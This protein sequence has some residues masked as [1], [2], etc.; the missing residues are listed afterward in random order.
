MD[1]IQK[2]QAAA[3]AALGTVLLTTACGAPRSPELPITDYDQVAALPNGDI[4]SGSIYVLYGAGTVTIP[5]STALLRNGTDPTQRVG[6]PGTTYE[7]GVLMLNPLIAEGANADGTRDGTK[8][9]A[10]AYTQNPVAL[11]ANTVARVINLSISI[12]DKSLRCAYTGETA[13]AQ[14]SINSVQKCQVINRNKDR[15]L[16]NDGVEVAR[17]FTANDSAPAKNNGQQKKPRRTKAG[18]G[19]AIKY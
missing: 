11:T 6:S 17:A 2:R 3:A 18:Y 5:G 12:D 19:R 9:W 13:G 10:C 1:N 14:V 16:C 8:Y 7:K 15:I 4:V